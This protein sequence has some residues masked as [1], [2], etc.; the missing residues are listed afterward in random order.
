MKSSKPDTTPPSQANS[1]D[2]SRFH[3]SPLWERLIYGG[4]TLL[5]T[6]GPVLAGVN[7]VTWMAVFMGINAAVLVVLCLLGA[8]KSLSGPAPSSRRGR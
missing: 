2:N 4:G 5:I 1:T 7:M 3:L 6:A 8:W